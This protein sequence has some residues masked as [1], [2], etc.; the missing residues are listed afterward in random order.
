MREQG[1]YSTAAQFGGL[2]S[3]HQHRCGP[4]WLS[5]SAQE[6]V[7]WAWSERIMVIDVP[8]SEGRV[9]TVHRFK[10]F[11]VAKNAGRHHLIRPV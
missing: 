5:P 2:A 10:A 7:S 11:W 9:F 1:D 4:H 8:G 6:L 3:R